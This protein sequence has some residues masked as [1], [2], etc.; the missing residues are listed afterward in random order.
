MT[1]IRKSSIPSAPR[2][3]SYG[4]ASFP[5]WKTYGKYD[6]QRSAERIELLIHKLHYHDLTEDFQH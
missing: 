5:T 4:P 6:Q 1:L 3:V 2:I